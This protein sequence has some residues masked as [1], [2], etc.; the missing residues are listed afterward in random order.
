MKKMLNI[1]M[2]IWLW[3]FGVTQTLVGFVGFLIHIR[4]KHYWYKGTVVTYV[5]GN[6]GGVSLGAFIFIDSD[7]DKAAA[8]DGNAFV[9]HERGHS[10]QSCLLGPIWWFVVG[11][12]SVLWAGIFSK[13]SKHTYYWFY[14]ER[15][16]DRLGGVERQVY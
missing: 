1:L 5:P 4:K 8:C 12:P 15:W 7:I 10:I 11:I 3:V 9:N 2:F 16:A 13:K 6:W 14:C